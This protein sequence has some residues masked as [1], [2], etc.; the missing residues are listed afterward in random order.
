MKYFH[1]FYLLLF[2]SI[3]NAQNT[4]CVS[5]DCKNGIGKYVY[6]VII[7]SGHQ[8]TYTGNFKDGKRYGQGEMVWL[9]LN[10][11][12][13]FPPQ[14][15]FIE[16]GIFDNDLIKG[17]DIEFNNG[18]LE[19][20]LSMTEGV[21]KDY[22]LISGSYTKFIGGSKSGH[23]IKQTGTFGSNS[24][25]T[26]LMHG[27]N[28][29]TDIQYQNTNLTEQ[30][31]CLSGNC[32]DGIGVLIANG[33]IF[34]GRFVKQNFISE[35]KF[36][37]FAEGTMEIFDSKKIYENGLYEIGKGKIIKY[38]HC[39]G[40]YDCGMHDYFVTIFHPF[41]SDEA[42]EGLMFSKVISPTDLNY[43]DFQFRD[44]SYSSSTMDQYVYRKIWDKNYK[45][46]K[47]SQWLKTIYSPYYEAYMKTYLSDA[48]AVHKKEVAEDNALLESNPVA[49]YY[50][51]PDRDPK[52]RVPVNEN[53]KP[54]QNNSICVCCHG[55]GTISKYDA[56]NTYQRY[57][58]GTKV[59]EATHSI[60]VTCTC[61]HGTGH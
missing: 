14:I 16:K 28:G 41:G 52:N 15:I 31:L 51:Y 8:A 2:A 56:G 59:G 40:G 54:I 27:W 57:D 3:T 34:K 26:V 23:Y 38:K 17:K 10:M 42:L 30:G 58:H 7:T 25:Y 5:G 53:K 4:G 24:K 13:G 46:K 9:N 22:H 11:P 33:A 37:Y 44:F 49:Y 18:N 29:G 61:C 48:D 21:L 36:L 32:D 1:I 12:S 55:L 39:I 35:K 6:D 50:K 43:F 60:N 47:S 20:T 19:D 45:V